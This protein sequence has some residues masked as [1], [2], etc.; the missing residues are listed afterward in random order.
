MSYPESIKRTHLERNKTIWNN[1]QRSGSIQVVR[2]PQDS[3]QG[4]EIRQLLEFHCSCPGHVGLWP[5][6][7]QGGPVQK[8]KKRSSQAHLPL[9]LNSWIN[10][11]LEPWCL[12]HSSP[13]QIWSCARERGMISYRELS[14]QSPFPFHIEDVQKERGIHIQFTDESLN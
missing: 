7:V 2:E 6:A 12:P 5:L 11:L 14:I 1:V 3:H 4:L 9:V 10:I 8:E 13:L